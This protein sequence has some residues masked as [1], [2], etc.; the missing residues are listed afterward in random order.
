VVDWL[1]GEGIANAANNFVTGQFPIDNAWATLTPRTSTWVRHRRA[2]R[3]P[4]TGLCSGTCKRNIYS[5]RA[6]TERK[7]LQ[8]IL[9]ALHF[10]I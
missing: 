7:L 1:P 10:L 9:S 5:F 3:G 6:L 2:S 4:E 8:S